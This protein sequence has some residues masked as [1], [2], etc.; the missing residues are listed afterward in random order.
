PDGHGHINTNIAGGYDVRAG[1]PFRDGDG[2]QLGLGINPY[3]RFAGTR[4]FTDIFDLSGCGDSDQ[5]LIKH[6]QDNGAQIS[7]N[8]WGCGGCA[9]TYDTS[10]QAYDAGVRD[11]DPSEPGNQPLIFIF[12]AG[13]DGPN[14]GT[15][16][17]PGNGKN[18]I[19]VG[20]SENDRPTWVDGC[21]VDPG[22]ADNI[23]DVIRFSSRGPAPG[24]R[25]KPEL[26]APGTHI[27]GTA[28]TNAGYN[29][30]GVCDQ[31]QPSGQATF[32]ASSGTSHS[33]PAVAGAASLY[34]YWLENR[35]NMT[36]PSPALMKAYFIA[37][38]TYLTGVAANDT[39]PSNAQGYGMPDMSLA[40]DDAARYLL[41]ETAVLDHTGQT[42]QFTS[43][44]ADPQKPLRIVMAYTDQAGL[45]GTSPQVNDLNLAVELGGE[46][47]Q[48]NNFSGAW[49]T[50]G[51]TA[52]AANNYEAIY[53]P[54]GTTG[55]FTITVTAYNVAGDGLPGNADNTDQDFALV[56][57]NCATEPGF[58]LQVTPATQAVCAPDEA[59][60]DVAVR[61]LLGFSDPVTLS[62]TGVFTTAFDTNPVSPDSNSQLVIG[63]TGG[64]AAGE[65][66]V[67][68][69]AISPTSTHTAP[70]H[71][72][73]Y[74]RLPDVVALTTPVDTAVS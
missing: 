70:L 15:I 49:S 19:T 26:I 43:A 51:G 13:N 8:S 50:P 7:S 61:S 54:L 56:C 38:P 62:A 65:Y 23:M 60:A 73:L 18:V 37:H 67:V 30:T 33:T 71:I 66:E 68:V 57:Y 46:V 59:V 28:S 16:G 20:A 35:Y 52:D 12:A 48:G 4:V 72:V 17:T 47:Y 34:Y 53:L 69:S 14:D 36:A 44:V 22:G 9:N 55:N 10:S 32:A 58:N 5:G 2:Y 29:G 3:G 1:W 25:V 21:G 63:N 27:Q 40:F 45:V 42:W 6:T 39:L 11:A 41:D 24:G 31:Y 64:A 74:D